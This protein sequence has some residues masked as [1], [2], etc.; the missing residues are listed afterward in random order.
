MGRSLSLLRGGLNQLAAQRTA[1]V[2]LLD[3]GN[4]HALAVEAAG[5]SAF[6]TVWAGIN[7]EFHT[8]GR[9]RGWFTGWLRVTGRGRAGPKRMATVRPSFLELEEMAT[10]LMLRSEATHG[11][12]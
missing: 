10:R 7:N 2:S 9:K 3:C 5:V 1:G 11:D 6:A 12:P 4:G 8:S